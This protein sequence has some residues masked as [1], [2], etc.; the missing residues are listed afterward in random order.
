[1]PKHADTFWVQFAGLYC[2]VTA[3]PGMK[4]I[5]C[6][7]LSGSYVTVSDYGPKGNTATLVIQQKQT[8][9]G[10]TSVVIKNNKLR[11]SLF[12]KGVPHFYYPL[13]P[14]V[15]QRIFMALWYNNGGIV[16]HAS[17]V[18][19]H[20]D[21]HIFVGD[22]GTGKTTMA[23]LSNTQ[24]GL[25]VLA[26][27]QVFIRKHSGKYV[28]YP[29]PFTQYHK[30]GNRIYLPISSFYILHKSSSFAVKP[31]PFIDSIR[32]LGH[33]I[34]I[35]NVSDIPIDV[36]MPSTLRHTM[37]DLIRSVNMKRLYFFPGKG[38]WEA[39]NTAAYGDQ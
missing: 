7:Y 10:N 17:A 39:I 30:E 35:L 18:E 8:V 38:L 37:F 34:Q 25:K 5:I 31:L 20:G 9:Y 21:A 26:D 27:N 1:M 16:F 2:L 11:Y 36:Q 24:Y 13:L 19:S 6:K 23:R 14:N 32:A 15:F 4:A 22:S 12:I 33:E 28:L 3:T 29:F